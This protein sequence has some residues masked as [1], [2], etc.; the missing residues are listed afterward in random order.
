MASIET[1]KGAKATTYRVTWVTGGKRGGARDSETC[2][3][4][5]IAKRFKALVVAAGEQRPAGYPKRCRGISRDDRPEVEPAP[6]TADESIP[7]AADDA[8]TLGEVLDRYL[9]Q[10]NHPA[11]E[12]QRIGYL[13]QF[14]R[15]V[16]AAIVTLEDGT[17]VGPLGG[18]PV[19]E[20]TAD[21]D[22]A[23][24]IWMQERTHRVKG[25]LVP[26]SAKTIHNIHGAI[27]SPVLAFAAVKGLIEANP[28]DSVRLPAKSVR[29]SHATR[30]PPPR[31][32]RSGSRSPTGSASSPRCT[33][34]ATSTPPNSW[35]PRLDG[36][37]QP[38]RPRLG[39]RYQRHLRAPTPEADQRAANILDAVMGGGKSRSHGWP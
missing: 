2:D 4:Y 33:R 29:S 34:C 9:G 11:E 3:T 36:H 18:L 1:R 30:S 13:R 7:P 26:Y 31:R 39:T 23:W 5:A 28:C 14:N 27:I 10:P 12:V 6:A 16:R 37:S 32:S 20:Y 17:R 25:E 35:R 8:P 38:P 19:T 24:V 15:H 22:Q 21:V